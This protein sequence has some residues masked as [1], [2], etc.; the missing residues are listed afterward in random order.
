MEG[1]EGH[2]HH[3]DELAVDWVG[4]DGW[5]D[6]T[7]EQTGTLEWRFESTASYYTWG[8]MYPTNGIQTVGITVAPGDAVTASSRAPGKLHA[9]HDRCDQSRE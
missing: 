8:E 4:I 6:G 9:N 3:G 2:L 7:V 1:A 5:T